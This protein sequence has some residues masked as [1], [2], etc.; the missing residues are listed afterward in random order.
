[1]RA[2]TRPPTCEEFASGQ[3]DT[4]FDS[5][6]AHLIGDTDDQLTLPRG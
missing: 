5:V 1:M 2:H 4:S 6:T 3:C